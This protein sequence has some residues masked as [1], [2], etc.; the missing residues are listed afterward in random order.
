MPA[1]YVDQVQKLEIR[2]MMA[3][4]LKATRREHY[5]VCKDASGWHSVADRQAAAPGH[6]IIAHI[7]LN[8]AFAE[9]AGPPWGALVT[10][11]V[12]GPDGRCREQALWLVATPT[13]LGRGW[14]WATCR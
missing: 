4:A 11:S 14:W 1:R 7:T 9:G 12:V 13:R 8:R 10:F 2:R 3:A 6:E 5:T